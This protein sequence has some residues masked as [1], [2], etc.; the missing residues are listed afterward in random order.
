MILDIIENSERYTSLHKGFKKAFEFLKRTDLAELSD[1]TYEIDSN[2][3]YAMVSRDEGRKKEDAK[4]ETHERYI[5]V[6]YVIS[7]TDTMGY[8][9]KKTC[10]KSND[11]YSQK[12]DVQFFEDAPSSWCATSSGSFAIF[13]PEDAH[14][15]LIADEMLHKVVVK[16]KVKV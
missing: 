2:L 10:H 6:Q 8:R 13:F 9:A 1:G 7:G 3:I 12:N 11:E 4:L 15:P 16:V 14:M 5:D